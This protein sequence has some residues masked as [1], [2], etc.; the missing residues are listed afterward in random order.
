MVTLCRN[1]L[2]A[3]F[4]ARAAEQNGLHRL[5]NVS[6]SLLMCSVAPGHRRLR[7]ALHP[8]PTWPLTCGVAAAAVVFFVAYFML[9]LFFFLVSQHLLLFSC[10]E[11]AA[12]LEWVRQHMLLLFSFERSLHMLQIFLC[13][14]AYHCCCSL[15]LW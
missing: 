5:M 14:P 7:V 12:A 4:V 15:S 6:D 3:H 9:L 10:C 11:Q 1:E 2:T 8:E 13:L